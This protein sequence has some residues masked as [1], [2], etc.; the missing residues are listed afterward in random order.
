MILC[1]IESLTRM[2]LFILLVL[3]IQLLLHSLV[4]KLEDFCAG[5]EFT[6]AMQEFADTYCHKFE[7]SE[8]QPIE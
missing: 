3:D 7:D 5:G 8:D 4:G 2:L 6:Q 1:K